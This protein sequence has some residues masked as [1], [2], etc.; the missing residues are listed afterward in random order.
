[1]IFLNDHRAH[2][3]T[4][5]FGELHGLDTEAI[6]ALQSV[7]ADGGALGEAFVGDHEQILVGITPDHVHVQQFVAFAE[8]HAVGLELQAHAQL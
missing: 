3:G 7:F 2:E 6:T 5:A 4:T 8:L 1:M